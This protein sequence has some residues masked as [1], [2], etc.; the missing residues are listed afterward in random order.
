ML[1]DR[2]LHFYEAISWEKIAKLP[3][4]KDYLRRAKEKLGFCMRE[5]NF[6]ANNGI[7]KVF[8]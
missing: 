2:R 7:S 1:S 8:L 4:A 5:H 3:R 6:Y